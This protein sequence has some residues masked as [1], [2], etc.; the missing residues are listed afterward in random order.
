MLLIEWNTL[1]TIALLASGPFWAMK[2]PAS[3][4]GET[5][6]MAA[7]MQEVIDGCGFDAP[8]IGQDEPAMVT[9]ALLI[10]LYIIAR[11][12]K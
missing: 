2:R 11:F 4:M 3:P 12:G 10:I 1:S 8:P 6:R 7:T 9:R 5:G